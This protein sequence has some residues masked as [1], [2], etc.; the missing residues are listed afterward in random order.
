MGATRLASSE[1]LRLASSQYGIDSSLART[2]S[3]RGMALWVLVL[4]LGY[5]MLYYV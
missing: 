1:A 5:L 3:I 2:W 4:L